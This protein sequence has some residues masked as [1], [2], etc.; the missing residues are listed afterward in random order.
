MS[1]IAEDLFDKHGEVPMLWLIESPD[2]GQVLRRRPSSS[3]RN[4]PPATTSTRKAS[5]TVLLGAGYTANLEAI[6]EFMERERMQ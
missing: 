5:S 6:L 4:R 3:T 1:R 2:K